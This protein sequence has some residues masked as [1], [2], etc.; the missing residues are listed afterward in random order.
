[1]V[2][3]VFILIFALMLGSSVCAVPVSQ[4]KAKAIDPAI[5]PKPPVFND[6][7]AVVNYYGPIVRPNFKKCFAVQN[8]KY[9]PSEMTWICLKDQK[10]LSLFAPDQTG[11]QHKIITYKIIGLSGNAG[12]KLKE[13]DKQV[14]EGFYKVAG[15]RPNLIAH[16]GLS[17]NYPNTEDVQHARQ[18]RRKNLGGDI[19]IH[20]S[21]WSTGC[22]A[23]GNPAIEE[24]FVLA[25]DMDHSKIKLIFAPY[26][27]NNMTPDINYKLQPKWLPG[28]YKRL[29]EA[30]KQYPIN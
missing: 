10:T 8:I 1:M 3:I 12:P 6:T 18:E 21:K 5:E 26:N 7:Q 25:H 23:M 20:G 24:L 14:P 15:F 17:V 22:L 4:D 9:P 27:L 28:L 29:S 13:G 19:L 2:P 16:I 30:L 11:K